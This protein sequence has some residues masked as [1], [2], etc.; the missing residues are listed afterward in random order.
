MAEPRRFKRSLGTLRYRRMF[1]LATEGAKTEPQYFYLFNNTETVIHV[2][3]LK[4]GS[5]SSPLQVLARME[6]HLKNENLRPEDEAWLVVDK[7]E[8]T[9]GQLQTLY[10]W[11][12]KDDRYGFSVSNPKFEFWLLL[13]FENGKGI[14]NSRQCTQ[15]LLKWLPN[16]SKGHVDT[17]KIAENIDAAIKRARQ[18]DSPPCDDWPRQTGTTVYKLVEQ[19]QSKVS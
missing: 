15:R 8:W 16:F 4:S 7:D 10:E 9:D 19:I 5:K 1:I 3:C 18:K 17:K 14:A 12:Q 13:H 2:K 11:S 6:K